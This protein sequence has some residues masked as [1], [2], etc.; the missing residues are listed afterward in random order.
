M[1]GN[2][3]RSAG[4]IKGVLTEE[5]ENSSRML[6][7]YRRALMEL[8]R[9]SLVK[10][11]IKGHDFYYLAF[12]NGDTVKFAYK[13]KLRPEEVSRYSE[14]KKMRAKYRRLI[15]E[16]KAQIVF[17]KRALHERKRRAI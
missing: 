4:V 2:K 13:G 9:G 10:K 16:L 6:E 3:K 14:T 17:L 7:R 5:L 1:F 8:P 11:K 12:R 15:S